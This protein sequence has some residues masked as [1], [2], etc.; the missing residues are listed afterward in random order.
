MN[1]SHLTTPHADLE[2]ERSESGRIRLT[3]NDAPTSVAAYLTPDEAQILAIVLMAE[4]GHVLAHGP[5]C[6]GCYV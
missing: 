4:S 3:L 5:H 1:A 2:V 6:G